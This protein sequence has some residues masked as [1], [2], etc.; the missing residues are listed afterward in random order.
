M[1]GKGLTTMCFFLSPVLLGHN[2]IFHLQKLRG[3][4]S[5]SLGPFVGVI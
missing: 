1:I 5:H 3:K 4:K 2:V